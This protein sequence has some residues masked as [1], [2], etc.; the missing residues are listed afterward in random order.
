[1][2]VTRHILSMHMPK[3][4][5]KG[6]GLDKSY[7]YGPMLIKAVVTKLRMAIEVDMSWV[8]IYRKTP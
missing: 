2:V 4:K 3:R 1:M 7:I 5:V 6:K 8:G